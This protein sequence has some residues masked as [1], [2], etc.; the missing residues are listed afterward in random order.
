MKR[1]IRSARNYPDTERDD[2]SEDVMLANGK[3]LYDAF[4]SEVDTADMT[5][6]DAECYLAYKRNIGV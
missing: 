4:G 2:W 5:E 3:A 6:Y 1:Y